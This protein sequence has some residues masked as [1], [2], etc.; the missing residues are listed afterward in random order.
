MDS[1]Y[2]DR[3]ADSIDFFVY[4]TTIGDHGHVG[5]GFLRLDTLLLWGSDEDGGDYRY[6]KI[7]RSR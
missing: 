5:K 6:V 2:S 7:H 1:G 3:P 4:D